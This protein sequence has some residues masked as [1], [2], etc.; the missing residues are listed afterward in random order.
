M[1]FQVDPKPVADVMA[2]AATPTEACLRTVL[3]QAAEVS[4]PP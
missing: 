1:G 4:P 2:A 3:Q